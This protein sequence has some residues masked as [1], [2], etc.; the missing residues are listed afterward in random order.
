MDNLHK[1][2]TAAHLGGGER[3]IE[4]QHK[5]GK[6]TARERL[7]ALFDDGSFSE[8]DTFVTHRSTDLGLEKQK[9][10]GD[11]VVTGYGLIDGRQVFAYAQDFTVL[12]GSLSQVAAQKISKVMDHAMKVGAPIIG[13]ND[14]GGARIQEGI[15]SLAGYGEIFRRN[16]LASGVVPQITVIAG[17]AAGGAVYSPALTDFIYMVEGI[18]QMYITGPDV[19]KAVTGEEVSH[20]D[21]GGAAAHASR[22]GVAHFTTESEDACFAHI[23]KLL[24]YIPSNNAESPPSIQIGDT[25]DHA[26]NSLRDIV[27]QAANQPYDVMEVIS[28]VVDNGEFLP[29]HHD[30]APNIVVGLARIDGK[31]VGVVANQ[32]AQMAG[33]LDIDASDKAAR[34]V[35]FCDAFNIPIVTFV[36][37]PGFMPGTHQEYGGLI[38]HGA[39]LLYAYVEA[40]TPKITVILRK[41]YGGA[42]IVMGSKEM[43]TDV[44]L[45]WP[46]SE[47]AVMGPEGAINV[48]RRRE[49]AE[50][51]DVEAKRAELV[52]DYRN[53]FANPY[54]AANRGYVD[55]VID[56]AETRPEL[57]KALRMLESKVDSIPPKK[58]GNIP[59]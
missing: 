56:P 12:G 36:D 51:E 54:I 17:P 53:Q 49:I 14:S 1:R 7:I 59:L 28:K 38:R 37:V 30:F 13:I 16:T 26:D 31:S 55:D 22:S 34:F 9:F 11:A 47:I 48:I 52:A 23:R 45:A 15:D 18:G 41:A 6:L 42:Y 35:R 5:R 24:S 50:A 3:R 8:L 29:V 32:A 27:P 33:M 39:K 4:S 2:R 44:N 19:V 57:I 40:T 25:N 21:L 43:R 46:N 20:E 10:E 58:H